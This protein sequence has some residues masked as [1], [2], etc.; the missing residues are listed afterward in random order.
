MLAKLTMGGIL[1]LAVCWRNYE[2]RTAHSIPTLML[3]KGWYWI[4][5]T[6]ILEVLPKELGARL[7]WSKIRVVLC[8]TATLPPSLPPQYYIPPVPIGFK[9]NVF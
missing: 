6:K 9:C 3:L 4:R 1:G 8:A 5:C 7:D 2:N